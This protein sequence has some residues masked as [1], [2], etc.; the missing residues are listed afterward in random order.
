MKK[1]LVCNTNGW[2]IIKNAFSV[3]KNVLFGDQFRP[4]PSI[5][6]MSFRD[7]VSGINRESDMDKIRQRSFFFYKK[8]S[9]NMSFV[10]IGTVTAIIYFLRSCDRTS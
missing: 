2:G 10:K 3:K 4:A 1:F 9:S 5:V 7:I 8:L 6:Q